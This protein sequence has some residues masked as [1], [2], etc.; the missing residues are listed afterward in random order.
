MMNRPFFIGAGLLAAG[1]S[2]QEARYASMVEAMDQSLGDL[3]DYL[4]RH[5]LTKNTVILFMS[6]NGGLSAEGRGG[7]PHTHNL[8]L[9]SGKGSAYEGGIREPMIISWPDENN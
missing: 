6:D 2:K 9:R 1:L 5:G 3:M 7:E 8:Q 4:D